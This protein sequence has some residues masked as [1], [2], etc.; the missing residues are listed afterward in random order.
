[1]IDI[2]ASDN[3]KFS[4]EFSAQKGS[5]TWIYRTVPA[6]PLP[7]PGEE[8]PAPESPE[9]E[10]TA[11]KDISVQKQRTRPYFPQ[12]H[13]TCKRDIL[14]KSPYFLVLELQA[15]APTTATTSSTST[16]TVSRGYFR[17]VSLYG[18]APSIRALT[19]KREYRMA[20]SYSDAEAVYCSIYRDYTSPTKKFRALSMQSPLG[21]AGAYADWAPSASTLPSLLPAK[22]ARL[23][24]V[25]LA[26]AARSLAA[27]GLMLDAAAPVRVDRAVLVLMR[28]RDLLDSEDG[29]GVDKLAGGDGAALERDFFKELPS[30]VEAQACSDKS[31]GK[32]RLIATPEA[33][34]EWF[35]TCSQL[36][37]VLSIGE[38]AAPAAADMFAPNASGSVDLVYQAMGCSIEYLPP[39]TTEH[40]MVCTAFLGSANTNANFNSNSSRLTVR[41]VFRVGRPADYGR[42]A[43]GCGGRRLLFHGTRP[44]N[45]FG[46]LARGM[47]LPQ[48]SI[49][50][51]CLPQVAPVNGSNL[52]CA[53]YFSDCGDASLRYTSPAQNPG[54]SRFMFACDVAL[55]REYTT[56]VPCPTLVAPPPGYDSVH[57]LP[58]DPAFPNDEYAVYTTTQQR[59]RYLVEFTTEDLISH[60]TS[61]NNGS[62]NS[63]NDDNDYDSVALKAYMDKNYRITQRLGLAALANGTTGGDGSKSSDNESS[64][65]NR[66]NSGGGSLYGGRVSKPAVNCG[67]RT[68]SGKGVPL[69]AV[70]V[71]AKVMDFVGEVTILQQYFNEGSEDIEGKFLFPLD[72][73][74]AITGFEAFVNDKHVV[75]TAKEKEAARKEYKEAVARGDGAYLLDEAKE[76]NVF[77]IAIG[78]IPARTRV[79]IKITYILE[80]ETEASTGRRRFVWSSALTSGQTLAGTFLSQNTT[81]S[82]SADTSAAAFRLELGASMSSHI[83]SVTSPT[84]A[85][86]VKKTSTK[87]VALYTQPN[88]FPYADLVILIETSEPRIP[89]IWVEEPK[90]S[91]GS[92]ENA[93]MLSLYP[94]MHGLGGSDGSDATYYILLDLSNS[95][96]PHVETAKEAAAELVSALPEFCRFNVVLFGTSFDTVFLLPTYKTQRTAATAIGKIHSA[97]ATWGT[98]NLWQ[99][100][101]ALFTKFEC[102]S[103]DPNTTSANDDEYERGFESKVL[104]IV[105]DGDFSND[106]NAIKL[107]RLHCAA[108]A[109]AKTRIFP[110]GVGPTPH[111]HNMKT[112]ARIGAGSAEFVGLRTDVNGTMARLVQ[113][114]VQPSYGSVS[115]QW[116]DFAPWQV[117]QAPSKVRSIFSGERAIVYGFLP[118]GCTHVTLTATDSTSGA[119]FHQIIPVNIAT[120]VKGRTIHCLTARTF[121]K[122][123]ADESI[124]D[125]FLESE[126]TKKMYRR[127]VIDLGVKYSI[128]TPLTSFIAVEDRSSNMD[129]HPD[130]KLPE[131]PPITEIAKDCDVDEIPHCSSWAKY[132][133]FQYP[134]PDNGRNAM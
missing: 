25:L 15:S 99:V 129:K 95:M 113:R 62:S 102:C 40:A 57:A 116:G 88:G 103:A 80:I 83:R 34:D 66:N 87:A 93:V 126:V 4:D 90:D 117:M 122:E 18:T 5:S 46:I 133:P 63:N 51:Y 81:S 77:T 60:T 8:D 73:G 59:L 114:T 56:C 86:R 89:S 119:V 123:W 6:Y 68:A 78:N 82:V 110:V 44:A 39:G 96:A 41:N 84:H 109:T 47:L 118:P 94:E 33:L 12:E 32:R 38:C 31:H 22:V 14:F 52:G 35:E 134:G 98:S 49:A 17:V 36:K 20:R 54:A 72:E 75:A 104:F 21:R 112:L 74:A 43:E 42:F 58:G 128:A 106:A 16:S 7:L 10:N 64:R 92:S 121:V 50:R 111:R 37:D 125:D 124:G 105:S 120:S 26:E 127:T 71:Y 69:E 85:I 65:N 76:A 67:L 9:K 1:M 55:G 29:T 131:T 101:M 28:M 91:S 53:L 11:D 27:R 100:F 132:D 115:V 97:Q 45:A 130:G 23:V 48:M 24:Q 19:C 3:I 108:T 13:I 2:E 79:V 61:N 30:D 107:A 70:S